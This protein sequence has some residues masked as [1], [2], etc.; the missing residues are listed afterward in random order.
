MF[1]FADVTFLAFARKTSS[2][3]RDAKR[4]PRDTLTV[5]FQ[6]NPLLGTRIVDPLTG[7]TVAV[8]CPPSSTIG[9][10]FLDAG[11][12]QG[13]VA[14]KCAPRGSA[15]LVRARR[16]HYEDWIALIIFN[17]LISGA[18]AFVSAH[19]WDLPAQV[20]VRPSIGGRGASVSASIAW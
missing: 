11:A 16:T 5:A 20:S 18:E 8:R 17:H 1:F 6:P 13:P 2:D 4:L 15:E 12:G 19:L 3:L 9:P 10:P 14:V 7:D